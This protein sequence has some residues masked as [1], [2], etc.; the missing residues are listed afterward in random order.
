[1]LTSI[2]DFLGKE[3][4]RDRPNVQAEVTA[5]KSGA[6]GDGAQGDQSQACR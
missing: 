4:P 5:A 1:M 3:Q 6:G 2:F